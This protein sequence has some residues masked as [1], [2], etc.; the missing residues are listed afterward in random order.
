[1]LFYVMTLENLKSKPFR[2]LMVH[3]QAFPP[4]QG[5]LLA[6]YHAL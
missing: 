3:K 1:M 4:D 6:L 2:P 5:L